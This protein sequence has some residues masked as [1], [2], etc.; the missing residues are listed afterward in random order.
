MK[1][2]GVYGPLRLGSTAYGTMRRSGF[3]IVDGGYRINN[4]SRFRL[5]GI[6]WRGWFIGFISKYAADAAAQ[7]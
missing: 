6:R 1:E 3:H 5:W 4:I 7:L 2:R